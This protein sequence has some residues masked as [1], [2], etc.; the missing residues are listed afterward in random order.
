MKNPRRNRPRRDVRRT[1]ANSPQPIPLPPEEPWPPAPPP[2]RPAGTEYPSGYPP[3]PPPSSRP[4]RPAYRAP[5]RRRIGC[6]GCLLLSPIVLLLAALI[7]VYLLA[8]M[9]A[10][11]LVLGIDYTEP[12]SYLGRS[13]TIVLT[14]FLPLKPYV[15]MLS[16][17]RD[18]WVLLPDGGENRINTAHFFAE[19]NQPGSGPAG[20]MQAIRQNF[21]VDVDY[22]VRFRFDDFRNVVYAMGGIDL[23]L[24]EPMAGYP[25]GPVH[26]SGHKALRFARNRTGSDDFFRMEHGQLLAKAAFRQMLRPKNWIRIPAVVRTV[27][28]SVDTNVPWWQWP[29]LGLTLLRVGPDGVD[30]R[31][32]DRDMTTPFTT[33]LGANVLLPNWSLINPV[34]M[35]MFGQ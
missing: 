17:P 5:R 10:N 35:E 26:L 20:A 32:I 9:R 4:P 24:P 22:Y 2:Y 19:A 21:G 30:N 12:G 11:I 14:T 31:T 34:L 3:P 27:L 7:A 8:P 25:A 15:G 33:D 28:A 29:R 13:D 18:L 1:A 23:D 16:I 6:T